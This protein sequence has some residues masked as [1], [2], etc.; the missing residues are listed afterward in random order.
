MDAVR[1]QA[2]P[3]SGALQAWS[4]RA[5]VSGD[6]GMLSAALEG[7]RRVLG[8]AAAAAGELRNKPLEGFLK[9]VRREVFRADTLLDELDYYRLRQEQEA[10]AAGAGEQVVP[11]SVPLFIYI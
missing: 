8:A 2:V 1:T 10:E 9:E 5:G 3:A 11:A 4:A 7:A 6:V